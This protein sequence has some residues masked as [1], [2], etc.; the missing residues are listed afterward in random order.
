MSLADTYEKIKPSI[1]AFTARYGIAQGLE[2]INN[3]ELAFPP[4]LGTGFI[5]NENGIIVTNDHVA[6]VLPGL[7]KPPYAPKG[8][9][10]CSVAL[11]KEVEEGLLHVR[12][13]ILDIIRIKEYTPGGIYYG[14]EKPDIAIVVVKAKGLPALE[15]CDSMSLKEGMEIATAGFPMGTKALTAPGWLHQITPT[16]QRGII[17]AVLPYQCTFPHALAINV[18]AQGG[19]SGSP[20]FFPE[21]GK[22]IGI[23]NCGLRE[24]YQL[25]KEGMF[26]DGYAVPT[27]ISH[28]VPSNYILEFLNTAQKD[29]RTKLPKDTK[30]LDELIMETPRDFINDPR[31]PHVT[32]TRID[33]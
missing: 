3:P 31:K 11:L 32:I 2:D 26:Q 21:N 16:L 10:P 7:F 14:S 17:S 8:K 6:K 22:V 13:E 12:L 33:I 9:I 29:T 19:A 18:M 4:I 15:L 27:N 24:F 5:I 30:T 1:I 28:V 25:S 23:L 20:V